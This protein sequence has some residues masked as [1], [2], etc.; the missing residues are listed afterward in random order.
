M[1][2]WSRNIPV[3]VLA[4]G[5][6]FSH[7]TIVSAA[8]KDVELE[9]A[10]N[11]EED[12]AG[13]NVYHGTQSGH[14]GHPDNADKNT[15]Y[16]KEGLTAEE[17]HY[18]AVTAYD[19]AGNE[20]APS[21]EVSTEAATVSHKLSVAIT[22]SGTV[23]SAPGGI[24]CTTSC[25]A[26]FA[27]GQSVTL[28]A[29]PKSN[30]KF[31]N[32]GGACSGSGS[33]VVTMSTAKS[34]TATFKELP[35][36]T[37]TYTLSVSITGNGTVSSDPSGIG[38]TTACK[39]SFTEG[40]SVTL[41]ATPQSNAT[42]S[43]WSGSCSGS[44]SCVVSMNAAKSVSATFV[45]APEPPTTPPPSGEAV[46][47]NFQPSGASVPSGFL[48]D[49]GAPYSSSR[50][51]G[52][53][54]RVN[55]RDRNAIKDQSRDTFIHFDTGTSATWQYNLANGSYLVSLV[56]GDPSYPQG[57]HHVMVEGRT[58]INNVTTQ[59][60]QFKVVSNFPVTVSDGKLTIKLT[61]S[62]GKSKTILN[63]VRIA[64]AGGTTPPPPTTPPPSGEAVSINFQPS[65]ASVP[66]GFIKDDGSLFS[67][68]RGYGW[69]T[70]VNTRDRNAIKDQSRD[71]FIH[72]DT[73]T[74]ATWQYNLANGSYLV[75]LV[76]GDPSYPQGPHH[77]MVEGRTAINNVTTQP[78]Q[79]KVVSNF[80]VTVSDGKLTIKLT[81]SG[82][83]SK[84]ILN[85]VRIA[86]AGGTTP[87]PPSSPPTS[88][89]AV[90]INFQPSGASV[91]SGFIKDDGATF[92]SSRGY[93]WST[94]VNTRER[95]YLSNQ[96]RDTF[97]HF[98]KGNTATW[99]YNLANG[100]YLVSLASGDPSYAQGPHHIEV[101]G[102]VVFPNVRTRVNEF[103]TITD[104]LVTVKDGNLTVNL[105]RESQHVILNY[106][107]ITPAP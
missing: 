54:T 101:E 20:S 14:Y 66:S 86:P 100:N 22:G 8:D 102:K 61:R 104:F 30:W 77:V 42:F 91:P 60:G 47:I 17:K 52:W 92:S 40:Q 35:P 9:W 25:N 88:G 24:G 27:E 21:E 36:T 10:P 48:K 1:F 39:A 41:S 50:G 33:C 95:H 96:S 81:R 32:W 70:R 16:R 63:Y 23:S 12:L 82:G 31:S 57:P 71:T 94:R 106:I 79:F 46:S 4:F 13:Y 56:S 6:L 38:C 62:G 26:T 69:S 87:P 15:S 98:D 67:S 59:P 85:Y 53:S 5:L 89:N 72:F 7:S 45:T 3:I 2:T 51:Y 90:S 103:L 107:T 49:S 18:F 97:I 75:S 55:T 19:N 78:G 73:G 64:P 99:Q 76:S 83:K 43:Q 84:T 105:Q 44:G 37:T 28:S 65:G 68:S 29:A 11:Q 74:S 93:G 58:A 34:V 80:P